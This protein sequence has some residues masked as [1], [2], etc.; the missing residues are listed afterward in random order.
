MNN[1][2]SRWYVDSLA[3]MSFT[4]DANSVLGVKD[5]EVQVDTVGG[6]V[7]VGKCGYI[8][9]IGDVYINESCKIN[10]IGLCILLEACNNNWFINNNDWIFNIRRGNK[11]VKLVFTLDKM[12]YGCII[13]KNIMEKLKNL[14]DKNKCVYSSNKMTRLS[15]N[16]K[17]NEKLFSKRQ[18]LKARDVMEYWGALGFISEGWFKKLLRNGTINNIP[19]DVKDIDNAIMIYGRPTYQTKGTMKYS[20]IS[21]KNTSITFNKEK[22]IL[23]SDV[24]TWCKR[25]YLISITA[26]MYLIT[27]YNLPGNYNQDDIMKCWNLC[28]NLFASYG[29]QIEKIICDGDSKFIAIKNAWCVG[30]PID[31]VGAYQHN[32]KIEVEIRIIKER[33]RCMMARVSWKVPGALIDSLTIAATSI[34]NVLPRVNE[35]VGAR[36]KLTGQNVDYL[37]MKFAWGQYGQG[38]IRNN[39]INNDNF[40]S[41]GVIV[42]FPKF[43]E[44]GSYHGLS[45]N[46]RKFV[47]VSQF[48]ASPTPDDVIDYMN[49]WYYED[50]IENEMIL[51]KKDLKLLDREY[52]KEK[53]VN[54]KMN[55]KKVAHKDDDNEVHIDSVD[56]EDDRDEGPLYLLKEDHVGSNIE[57]QGHRNDNIIDQGE[58]RGEGLEK[59]DEIILDPMDSGNINGDFIESEVLN[60]NQM[61][62]IDLLGRAQPHRIRKRPSRYIY[63]TLIN[64]DIIELNEYIYNEKEFWLNYSDED[65]EEYLFSFMSRIKSALNEGGKEVEDAISKEFKQLIDKEVWEY[66]NMSE[67][68]GINHY[69]QL[70]PRPIS[71]LLNVDK[72]F[73]GNGMFTKWKARFCA[74]GNHQDRELYNEEELSSPTMTLESIFILLAFAAQ[75]NTH[76]VTADITGAYLES[77]LDVNDVVYMFLSKDA[78]DEL[79]KIDPKIARHILIDG[80]VLVRLLKALYG[81]IQ[82]AKLW[83][84]KLK[85]IITEYGFKQHP[86]DQCVF[87][88][89]LNGVLLIVGFHVDDLLMICKDKKMIDDFVAYLLT[90]FSNITV[91]DGVQQTYLGMLITKE[92][93]GTVSVTMEGYIDKVIKIYGLSHDTSVKDPQ[94]DNIFKID[95][96]SI[97]LNEPRRKLFHRVVYMLVYLGKRVRFDIQM[98]MSFLAGRVTVATEEDETKLF[99]VLRFL[100]NSMSEKIIFRADL[101]QDDKGKNMM[102]VRIWADSSWGCHEDGTSRSAIIICVNG[103]CVAS[104]T[105]KQKMITL[106]ATEAELVCLTD[107]A[108][109]GTWTRMF[110][111]HIVQLANNDEEVLVMT[112]MQDNES[113]IKIQNAGQ[114]NKQRTRHLTI[115]LWWTQE[116]VDSGVAKI[117]WIGTKSMIADFLT[118]AL[119]GVAFKYCWNVAS[120][121]TVV[122]L[123]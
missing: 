66:V 2:G 72:K 18:L 52:M 67:Q 36:Q 39:Q 70:S 75:W 29:V 13:D 94:Q 71:S 85:E 37:Q 50:T 32:S 90:C 42:L 59:D 22:Q 108:R 53:R 27:V 74:C 58:G 54:K 4:G 117:E 78:V 87:I 97:A 89:I 116:L 73:D 64:D 7:K 11:I 38:Y 80:R 102:D 109:L 21:I 93:N 26:P 84:K 56:G 114:R 57:E 61:N 88:L 19:F 77:S 34:L 10:G 69:S 41:Q 122:N 62:T 98:A 24:M 12:G 105:H 86:H 118:K 16:V 96:D 44:S 92:M 28:I 104:H 115:R 43:N 30:V 107:A 112:M 81:T 55:K 20:K 63:K 3:N 33:M 110:V 120:G 49:N 35:S 65:N 95:D 76:I 15:N 103:T 17:D 99:R 6:I 60:T 91:H 23:Y 82:A 113:V 9:I 51:S 31:N 68:E 40:R 123:I 79:K 1:D 5:V 83:Y 121:N 119:H 45:L 25:Q 111:E 101:H 46:T 48:I 14:E 100:H 47:T 106:H 8:P